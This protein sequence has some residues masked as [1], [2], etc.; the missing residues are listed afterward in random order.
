MNESIHNDE[1]H[2][3]YALNAFYNIQVFWFLDVNQNKSATPYKLKP[4]RV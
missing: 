1:I 4:L 2:N 3:P